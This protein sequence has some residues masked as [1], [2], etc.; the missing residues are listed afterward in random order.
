MQSEKCKAKRHEIVWFFFISIV[1]ATM[2]SV[3]AMQSGTKESGFSL[4][5]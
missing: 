2:Q 4:Y 1:R 5:L 3:N